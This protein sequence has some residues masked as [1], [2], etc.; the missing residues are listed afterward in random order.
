MIFQE[1]GA[2]RSLQMGKLLMK[3]DDCF[4][5]SLFQPLLNVRKENINS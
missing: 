1:T 5:S 2:L 4:K 3:I